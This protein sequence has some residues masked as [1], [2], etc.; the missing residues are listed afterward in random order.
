VGKLGVFYR[1]LPLV[2]SSRVSVHSVFGADG[3]GWAIC[4]RRQT[5]NEQQDRQSQ[6][7]FHRGD[8]LTTSF[9][10]ELAEINQILIRVLQINQHL[11]PDL[12]PP[13]PEPY[14]PEKMLEEDVTNCR[15]F[16]AESGPTE[17]MRFRTKLYDTL[18]SQLLTPQPETTATKSAS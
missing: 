18:N 17:G 4:N 2:L 1:P 12:L 6:Y 14:A 8:S 11:F 3:R 15:Q 9:A 7:L 13:L 10:Q 5:D 16:P